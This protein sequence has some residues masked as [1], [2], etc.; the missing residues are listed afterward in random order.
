MALGGDEEGASVLSGLAGAAIVLPSLESVQAGVDSF[1]LAIYI[2]VPV[3]VLDIGLVA[4][5][6][7]GRALRPVFAVAGSLM[8]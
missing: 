8:R 3:V 7:V 5:L 4:W 2:G 1:R 6:V